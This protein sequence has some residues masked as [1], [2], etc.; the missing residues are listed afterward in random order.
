MN[1]SKREYFAAKALQGLL[2]NPSVHKGEKYLM[3]KELIAKQA[4]EKADAV[5]LKLGEESAKCECGNSVDNDK[6]ACMDEGGCWLCSECQNSQIFH[7][8][9]LINYEMKM[10][11]CSEKEAELLVDSYLAS[12]SV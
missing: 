10:R 11:S 7:R 6:D 4:V 8:N 3:Q 2:S 1:I 5:L 12:T 9:A